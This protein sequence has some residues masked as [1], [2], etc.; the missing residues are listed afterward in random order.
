MGHFDCVTVSLHIL[1]TTSKGLRA[2]K[3]ISGRRFSPSKGFFRRV[4]L[5]PKNLDAVAG[6]T[7]ER[8]KPEGS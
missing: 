5:E 4:K 8:A 3:S 7:V 2:R 6:S 1:Y